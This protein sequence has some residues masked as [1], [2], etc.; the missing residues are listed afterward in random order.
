MAEVWPDSAWQVASRNWLKAQLIMNRSP[1]EVG[2]MPDFESLREAVKHQEPARVPLCEVLVEYPI[3]SQFL[4]RE[5]TADDLQSQL[6]F[7]VKAGY[8]YIP[9]TVGMMTPGGVTA[10]SAISKVIKENIVKDSP[11][12]G[13]DTAWN[14]EYTSF[15]NDREDFEKFPWEAAAKLDLSKFDRVKGI[16]P[17]GMKV[18]ALSGKIFTLGWMLM[19]FNNFCMSLM[20]DERLVA[21][22]LGK[23]ADIQLRGLEKILDMPHIGAI[24][25]VDDV[26]FGTGPMVPPQALRDHVFSH[27]R[28]MAARCHVSNLLVF[29][30][31]DGNLMPLME[32]IIAIGVDVLQPIDPTCMDIVKVKEIYGDRLCL[33]GNVSNELLRSGTP[34]EVD[35]TVKKLIRKLAHG[36]GYCVGSGNSVAA[37]SRFENYMAMRNATL[38]YGRYPIRR[39]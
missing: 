3:Q 25:L 31:S 36:G 21:D 5:V 28:K 6:D 22:V 29:M 18:I 26:A 39:G 2:I 15:I 33:A 30:H 38:K 17:P 27:Y 1:T 14:L 12:A 11:E 34:V 9:L 20:T 16:L 37:W 4:G 13:K 35:A 8:D 32:D 7:W 19:G 10:E 24:W 23:I